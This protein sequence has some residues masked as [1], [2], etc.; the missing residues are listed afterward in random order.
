MYG[1]GNVTNA[2]FF[3]EMGWASKTLFSFQTLSQYFS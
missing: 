1:K 2:F 3:P